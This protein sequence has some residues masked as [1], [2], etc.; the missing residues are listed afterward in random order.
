[1]KRRTFLR[2]LNDAFQG[3]YFAA[4][5]ERNMRFHLIAAALVLAASLYFKIEKIELLFVLTAIFI[6]IITE[7]LNTALEKTVDLYTQEYHPLA[8]I[9]KHVAA[10]AVLC[11]AIFALIVAYLVFGDKIL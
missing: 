6:V 4:R 5:M 11:A 1:M 9:V 10:G 7:L 2:S 3:V 8:E